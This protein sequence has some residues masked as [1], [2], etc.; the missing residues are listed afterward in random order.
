MNH[1][2]WFTLG[3]RSGQAMVEALVS[4]ILLLIIFMAIP[5]IGKMGEIKR[6]TVQASRYAAWER[7]VWYSSS[8]KKYSELVTLIPYKREDKPQV[9]VGGV[10]D[11]AVKSESGLANETMIRIF[12]DQKRVFTSK[13]TTASLGSVS[14]NKFEAPGQSK[15]LVTWTGGKKPSGNSPESKAPGYFMVIFT[16]IM[17]IISWSFFKTLFGGVLDPNPKGY[18]IADINVP[19][20]EN[21]TLLSTSRKVLSKGT[22]AQEKL[23]S[24]AGLTFKAK[25]AILTDTWNAQGPEHGKKRVRGLVPTGMLDNA[26]M[27]TFFNFWGLIFPEFGSSWTGNANLKWGH[28]DMEPIPCDRYAAPRPEFAEEFKDA[29][30]NVDFKIERCKKSDGLSTYYD[31]PKK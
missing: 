28:V 6:Q 17:D 1:K 23:A 15:P 7:T 11:Y 25:N 19:I 21:L 22:G 16:P 18:Y 4:L 24:A 14:M 20:T 5:L 13:D 27:N 30:G 29:L 31:I 12:G 3:Q 8:P 10:L 9:Q 2:L 26:V